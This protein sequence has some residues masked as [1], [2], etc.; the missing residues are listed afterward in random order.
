M[1]WCITLLAAAFCLESFGQAVVPNR[2]LNFQVVASGGSSCT[3][4][5]NTLAIN[6][7]HSFGNT[8]NSSFY[9]T[10]AFTPSTN[11]TLILF[12]ASEP[13]SSTDTVTNTGTTQLTWWKAARTNYATTS[14]ST[15]FVS[16]WVTQLP[17]GTAPFSMT[18]VA[19]VASGTGANMSVLEV[20]GADQSLAFGTNAIVQSPARGSNSLV[21]MAVPI[22]APG[23]N[24]FNALI[25]AFADSVNSAS[26]NAAGG[27]TTELTETSFN[28]TAQGL[29]VEYLLAASGQTF[30]TN[31]A[32]SRDWGAIALEVKAGTNC[33]STAGTVVFDSS[34]S[35]TTNNGSTLKYS[36]TTHSV[37]SLTGGALLFGLAMGT[38]TGS[39]TVSG[40]PFDNGAAMVLITNKAP[41]ASGLTA[42]YRSLAP[43]SGT[44]TITWTNT[45]GGGS[46]VVGW[47]CAT[48]S[49][50][51]QSTPERTVIA[52]SGSGTTSTAT[53]TSATGDLILA[54]HG[55]GTAFSA[56]N[57][58]AIGGGTGIQ[59]INNNSSC[60]NSAANRAAGAAS[61]AMT[62]TLG[63]DSWASLGI[64]WQP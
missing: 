46:L 55:G 24:G 10:A 48:A 26:D 63:S 8:S 34:S 19:T 35:G 47:W 39:P 18:V 57:Q 20:T 32:S 59:N 4:G 54:M 29:T 37:G 30:M 2:R 50:V 7:L 58:T 12:L 52:A 5:T 22:T 6:A 23:N 17:Q 42:L 49:G 62:G 40:V 16:A 1:R 28:S 15:E 41:A 38:T 21:G 43:A 56:I 60:G 13:S 27:G 51:N 9:A 3:P 61:V 44:H 14:S 45:D 64:S 53:V 11:A 33:N 31:S 36:V 25:G